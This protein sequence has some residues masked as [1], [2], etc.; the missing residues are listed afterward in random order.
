M[1][2][3]S[4]TRIQHVTFN[5]SMERLHSYWCVILFASSA[6][7]MNGARD[8]AAGYRDANY[9]ILIVL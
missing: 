2:R 3:Y 6:S 5:S 7:H 1:D 4:N 8:R 9:R